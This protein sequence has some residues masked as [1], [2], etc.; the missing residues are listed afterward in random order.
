M[1]LIDSQVGRW[2]ALIAEALSDQEVPT[3]RPTFVRLDAFTT[4]VEARM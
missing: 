4:G 2:M 3:P 1:I